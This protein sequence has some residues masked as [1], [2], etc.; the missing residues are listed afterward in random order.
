M[1]CHMEAA[2]LQLPQ[3]TEEIA[4]GCRSQR[5]PTG[6]AVQRASRCETQVYILVAIP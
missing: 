5:F 1:V 6:A 4:R 2:F 3:S